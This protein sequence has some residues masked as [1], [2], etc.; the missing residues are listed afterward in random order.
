MDH[1]HD[2]P[3]YIAGIV[4]RI[5]GILSTLDHPDNVHLVFSAHGLPMALV[6]RAT[7]IPKQIE[8]TVQ[9]VRE[10][11]PGKIPTCSATKAK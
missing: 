9:L 10:L 5:N 2:H 8:E 1:F 11:A 4:E 3:D 6:K 7:L